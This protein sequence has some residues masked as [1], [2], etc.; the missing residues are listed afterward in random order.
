MIPG[1]VLLVLAAAASIPWSA[2]CGAT[3]GAVGP[4]A[5]QVGPGTPF[6][7]NGWLSPESDRC[8]RGALCDRWE[9]E[10][11]EGR[12]I[13][14]ELNSADFVPMLDVTTPTGGRFGGGPVGVLG[15]P[16]GTGG[17]PGGEDE[18]E[19]GIAGRRVVFRAMRS[20]RVGVIVFGDGDTGDSVDTRAEGAYSLVVTDEGEDLKPEDR[21]LAGDWRTWSSAGLTVSDEADYSEYYELPV[22]SYVV[23][24]FAGQLV[25]IVVQAADSIAQP[26]V[27]V[28]PPGTG[29]VRNVFE[30]WGSIAPLEPG[31]NAVGIEFES[32]A[33]GQ[34]LLLVSSLSNPLFGPIDATYA[35]YA[36]PDVSGVMAPV[37]GRYGLRAWDTWSTARGTL[38]PGDPVT[39][40]GAWYEEWALDVA[41]GQPVSVRVNATFDS[42]LRVSLPD[43]TVLVN[44]DYLE[45]D[46]GIDFTS[47]A[48]GPARVEVHPYETGTAGEYTLLASAGT[49]TMVRTA[50]GG[51]PVSP[52]VLPSPTLTGRVMTAA[53]TLGTAPAVAPAPASAASRSAF[54]PASAAP[55]SAVPEA[56]LAGMAVLSD[57]TDVLV[58]DCTN[59][60]LAACV[61]YL[62]RMRPACAGGN[63]FACDQLPLAERK[64]CSLGHGPSCRGVFDGLSVAADDAP[65]RAALR[66][67]CELDSAVACSL[68]GRALSDAGQ[69]AESLDAFRA[70]CELGDA[71]ACDTVAAAATAVA[72]GP[73]PTPPAT[74]TAVPPPT[75]PP[76]GCGLC[77][78]GSSDG[79]RR[80]GR[81]QVRASRGERL[82]RFQSCAPELDPDG[83]G[84]LDNVYV[85]VS[86]TI[87]PDGSMERVWAEVPSGDERITPAMLD[88][89]CAVACTM[90]FDAADETTRM[91]IVPPVLLSFEPAPQ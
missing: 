65:A 12:V 81:D 64:A 88:C 73:E 78:P 20:G 38:G 91:P 34:A 69:P 9:F 84:E 90:A 76:Q 7:T 24:V 37:G 6:R 27:A 68:L 43:G 60:R 55:G 85:T 35:L 66:R 28:L 67:G 14:I 31:T 62:D 18:Q 71:A 22:V 10:V 45:L 44:D 30:L 29:T 80:W 21:P 3:A 51:Q 15:V 33:D 32:P 41:A 83:E 57:E 53:G 50:A 79:S 56:W 48:S 26:L 8:Y 77:N 5:V 89:V 86:L 54:L 52:P 47:A 46:P 36:D 19:S 59:D 74:T 75:P 23:P 2:G 82:R 61:D 70:A 16:T 17:G 58:G 49:P 39:T 40:A 1:A 87:A 72:P 4:A 25:G 42:V 63:A 13:R 11:T